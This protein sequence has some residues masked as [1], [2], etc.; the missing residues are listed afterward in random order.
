VPELEAGGYGDALSFTAGLGQSTVN[1]EPRS[2]LGHYTT[3]ISAGATPLEQI[4]FI[5][6]PT[7]NRRVVVEYVA[8]PSF[9]ISG[10]EYNLRLPPGGLE[11]V[12]NDVAMSLLTREQN[13]N[14]DFMA[15]KVQALQT[16]MRMAKMRGGPSPRVPKGKGY[17]A[18]ISTLAPGTRR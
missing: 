2:S 5:P 9:T 7:A 8:G 3:P 12:I 17:Y 1:G 10:G 18:R 4:E 14:A 15:R 6:T 11:Y 16:V 13:E